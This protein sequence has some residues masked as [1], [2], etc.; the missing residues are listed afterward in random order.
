MRKITGFL[1]ALAAVGVLTGCGAAPQ[2]EK[3]AETEIPTEGLTETADLPTDPET[4]APTD[5]PVSPAEPVTEAATEPS[6]E[7]AETVWK[8]AFQSF[9][10]G[11]D[12]QSEHLD[13]YFGLI[14]LN[15]DAVPE[16]VI[17]EDV[18]VSL[19]YCTADGDVVQLMEA[20]YKGTA[21]AGGN[22]SFQPQNSLVAS[23]FST[24]GGGVGYT[25]YA[26]DASEGWQCSELFFNSL[27]YDSGEIEHDEI[28]DTADEYG[29]IYI[30]PREVTLSSEWVS[31]DIGSEFL[32]VLSA[33]EIGAAFSA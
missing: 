31:A 15:D 11:V 20:N 7:T 21:A 19:Y 29:V 8:Q 12:A 9:L 26:F 27:A 18:Y 1:T 33:E 32:H 10:T 28:W 24:M 2:T 22:F 17:F 5:A 25:L 16:L 13:A 30:G 4:E 14:Q 6:G 23:S 3:P